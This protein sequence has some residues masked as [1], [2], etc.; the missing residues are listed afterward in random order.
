MS[1]P[2]IFISYSHRDE[3]W[4]ERLVRH[5]KVLELEDEL[6]VWHDR[7]IAAGD[8]WLAA[9]RE[10]LAGARVAVLLIT[11]DFLT[12]DFI[13]RE[14]VPALLERRESEGVRVIPLLVIP[15]SS[16]AAGG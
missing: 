7:E 11:A 3:H 6:T 9:I 8:D 15:G 5:L 12:S 14:E 10:A 4:K 2:A 13:R 1:R 16:D